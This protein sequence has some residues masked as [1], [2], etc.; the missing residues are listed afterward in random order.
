VERAA[1]TDGDVI[2]Y[3]PLVTRC[4][5]GLFGMFEMLIG[6]L[7]VSLALLNDGCGVWIFLVG[8]RVCVCMIIVIS[9]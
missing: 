7:Y 4:A 9:K 8:D 2:S 3:L 1:L 6:V 5:A